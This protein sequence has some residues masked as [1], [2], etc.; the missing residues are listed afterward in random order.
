[1]MINR[2]VA[3]LGSVIL[4]LFVMTNIN[5]AQR[6][7]TRG[8][9]TAA[10]NRRGA[11]TLP[12]E[13]QS[14]LVN[15]YCTGCHNDKTKSGG[16]T[17]ANLDLAHTEKNAELAEK[18]IRKL[19]AGMMP[20]P[21]A[22]RPEAETSQAFAASLES[23]IDKAAAAHPNPGRRGFQRLSQTEYARSIHDL[24]NIDVD[25]AAL[26]PP[27]SLHDG[28]D[29]IAE[30]QSFSPAVLEDTSERRPGSPLRLWAILKQP[31]HRRRTLSRIRRT[32]CV[33]SR[34]RRLALAAGSPLSITS[35]PTASMSS[36]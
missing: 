28:F 24:L 10:A 25:V 35:R 9:A 13:S 3:I 11:G 14:A 4:C 30:A 20:P 12:L 16:M 17:L 19:R 31:R 29:N 21:G 18:I 1:M 32:N 5:L 8:P 7:Q 2:T 26:L 34:E 6:E 15:Q 33:T 23:A 27:D 36:M 22:K